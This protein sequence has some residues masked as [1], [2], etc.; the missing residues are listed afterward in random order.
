MWA[1]VLEAKSQIFNFSVFTDVSKKDPTCQPYPAPAT[2]TYQ[3]HHSAMKA[4]LQLYLRYFHL[5]N[6][7]IQCHEYSWPWIWIIMA[8][9]FS[10][11]TN[12]C[13]QHWLCLNQEFWEGTNSPIQW[14]HGYT[15]KTPTV[16]YCKITFPRLYSLLQCL[17]SLAFLN[18]FYLCSYK[19][20]DIC[21]LLQKWS[22]FSGTHCNKITKFSFLIIK[23][24]TSPLIFLLPATCTLLSRKK[25]LSIWRAKQSLF[26][27]AAR[28]WGGNGFTMAVWATPTYLMFR[29][30][31]QLSWYC[32]LFSIVCTS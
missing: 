2:E 3:I 21:M 7:K 32:S 6:D 14:Q 5:T 18:H 19:Y 25:I 15:K 26:H 23:N 9:L 10:P 1:D 13:V 17:Q 11:L 27:R 22:F 29:E 24:Q 8:H 12:V 16:F 31:L 20:T 4:M 28:M 30:H